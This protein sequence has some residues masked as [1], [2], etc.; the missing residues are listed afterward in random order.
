MAGLQATERN[1]IYGSLP[2]IEVPV[3]EALVSLS[4]MWNATPASEQSRSPS[5]FRASR[6]NFILHFGKEA[7][8][9]DAQKLFQSVIGF[10]KRYPCRILA[11]CPSKDKN[12]TGQGI[13]CKIF[14]ECYIGD[15]HGDMSCCEALI[16][17][18]TVKEKQYLEDQISIFLESDL[19][20]YYWPYRFDSPKNLSDYQSFFGNANRV[21]IDTAAETYGIEALNVPKPEIIHDLA[22][23]RTLSLRQSIGQFFSAF[24]V[25]HILEGLAAIEVDTP[26][27]LNA[28]L[29]ALMRWIQSVLEDCQNCV[30]NSKRD[31]FDVVFKKSEMAEIRFLYENENAARCQLNLETGVAHFDATI[32]GNR[33]SMSAVIHLLDSDDTLAE[34]LFFG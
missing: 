9:E 17:G 26:D 16:F 20:T 21:V 11:L 19:P 4:N 23:A 6:M 7:T 10:S 31:R 3:G 18:Y 32:G 30:E 33:H 5:E 29:R 24:P 15:G 25:D 2:G 8:V 13:V 22:F 1:E 14:S 12:A 28:E 34:A 27:N